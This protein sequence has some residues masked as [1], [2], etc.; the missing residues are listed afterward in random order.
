MFLKGNHVMVDIE[1]LSTRVAARVLQVAAVVFTSKGIVDA[2]SW[3]LN[4]YQQPHRHIEISTLDFWLKTNPTRLAELTK[5]ASQIE[6]V[7]EE[8]AKLNEKYS[9]TGWWAHSPSFDMMILDDLFRGVKGKSPWT[10]RNCFDT[11][12]L[13]LVSGKKMVKAEETLQHD[14]LHDARAQAEWVIS[15]AE[16]QA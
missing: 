9:P 2:R 7:V 3:S 16:G 1:T 5:G 15:V 11:R 6:M 13:S 14:A 8:F 12:T 4:Q 10:H